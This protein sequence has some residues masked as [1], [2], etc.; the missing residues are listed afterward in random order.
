[1]MQKQQQLQ[2][3]TATRAAFVAFQADCVQAYLD[4]E[5]EVE[6]GD[7]VGVIQKVSARIM[8]ISARVLDRQRFLR[9]CLTDR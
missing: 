7:A 6:G 2:E 9:E 1:M 8:E 3:L 5:D 4:A